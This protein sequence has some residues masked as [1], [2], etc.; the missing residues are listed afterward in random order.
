MMI[1]DVQKSKQLCNHNSL[2]LTGLD[3]CCE[4]VSI[5]TGWIERFAA[6]M[7]TSAHVLCS[8]LEP[9]VTIS[10]DIY[11]DTPQRMLGRESL[12]G[13]RLVLRLRGAFSTCYRGNLCDFYVPY[14]PN[15]P[16][17]YRNAD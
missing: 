2:D 14:V 12:P 15:L 8:A 1:Q 17:V 11:C 6:V 5:A 13:F 7:S 9:L 3:S 16:V 10:A 4:L